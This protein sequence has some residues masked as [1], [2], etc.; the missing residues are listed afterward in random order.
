MEVVVV[1]VEIMS[2]CVPFWALKIPGSIL[3]TSNYYKTRSRFLAT[4]SFLTY[5]SDDQ[6]TAAAAATAAATAIALDY[7]TNMQNGLF[8]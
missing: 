7:T 3:Q 2:Y 8:L 5:V 6:S 4:T 1:V